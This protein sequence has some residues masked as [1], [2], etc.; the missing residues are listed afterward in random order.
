MLRIAVGGHANVSN[1]TSL[2]SSDRTDAVSGGKNFELGPTICG[3]APDRCEGPPNR[4][5]GDCPSEAFKEYPK[6]TEHRDSNGGE[7][8]ITNFHP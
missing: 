6:P 3:R 7:N 4:R 5:L 8:T 2:A 1:V